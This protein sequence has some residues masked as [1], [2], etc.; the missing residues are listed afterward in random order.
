[1]PETEFEAVIGLET[2]VQLNTK[3]KMF[4][5]S[6]AGYQKAAPNTLVD[7]VSMALPGTLPVVNKR[8]VES[9][10]TIGL[11][12]NCEVAEVTKFDRKQYTY[13]DLMKGYQ[14][15][16][17]DEPICVNGWLDLPTETP[18]RVGINRVHME[19]DVARLIH[20]DSPTG[21]VMHSLL[22]IN[23]AGVPLMEVVTEPDM[24]TPEQVEAYITTLQSIIRYLG[25]G[26]ANMEEGSF[27]CDANISV[28]PVGSTTLGEKV[29]VKNM[30][31][32]RAVREAVEYEIE[33]QIAAIRRG[34]RIVQETRGWMDGEKFTV[35]Q[36]SK[37]DAHD[38]RYFPEPDIPPIHIGREW[39]AEIDAQMPELP[40]AKKQ[41]F[42]GSWGLSDYDASLLVD[43]RSSAEYFES[44][45]ETVIGEA[46]ERSGEFRQR[47]GQLAQ[48]RDGSVDARKRRPQHPRYPS[49]AGRIGNIGSQISKTGN[50]QQLGE[51]GV[52]P[53]VRQGRRSRR[54][55]RAVGTGISGRCG[56]VGADNRRGSGQK[57]IGSRRLS[58]GE[59][60]R[61]SF[62][63]GPSD[64]GD[65]RSCRC[66]IGDEN[67]GRGDGRI[68]AFRH[69]SVERF[70]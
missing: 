55:D 54:G 57:S 62:L 52:R 11:A 36:R 59:D 37:E 30:N 27:R 21:G 29:E 34:E 61:N 42:V 4:S 43:S 7:P 18:W 25:V 40:L 20:I 2:H 45:M 63:D 38:Y 22:D 24:R 51:T 16:Q 9:A 65:P 8:A 48:R 49:Q 10:I 17:Y 14:I 31:R 50:Q 44:V 26:T 6:G 28:R 60:Q 41:R 23:R 67:V 70:C 46:G 33:R 5:W 69:A 3:S 66:P 12:L 53:D 39:V 58:L 32:V 56:R 19:E 68:K 1:M 47:D 35:T 64:E 15:S 13:P